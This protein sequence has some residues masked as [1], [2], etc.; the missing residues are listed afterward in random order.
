M[1]QQ[2]S[3][4]DPARVII[5]TPS[6]NNP[7]TMLYLDALQRVENL[8]KSFDIRYYLAGESIFVA[9]GEFKTLE[10]LCKLEAQPGRPVVD[11]VLLRSFTRPGTWEYCLPLH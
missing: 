2:T 4:E 11:Q 8:I 10:A 6:L 1:M 5:H 9:K 7:E 3:Q